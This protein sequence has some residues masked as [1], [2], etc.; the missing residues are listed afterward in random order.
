MCSFT[1]NKMCFLSS[2]GCTEPLLAKFADGGNKKKVPYQQK[3]WSDRTDVSS[4]GS[5]NFFI[6][7]QYTQESYPSIA[8]S[9]KTTYQLNGVE[10]YPTQ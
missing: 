10:E 5:N 8:C 7:S 9:Y 6:I 2:E 1:D 3:L 4:D